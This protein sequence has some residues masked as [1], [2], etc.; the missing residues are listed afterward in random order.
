MSHGPIIH[1]RFVGHAT[2]SPGWMSW[3]DQPFTAGLRGSVWS[4]L[5]IV[6][7]SSMGIR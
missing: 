3:H 6:G 5:R 2:T 7:A 1:P 4:T